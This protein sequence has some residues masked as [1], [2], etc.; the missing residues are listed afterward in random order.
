MHYTRT[1]LQIIL[2]VRCLPSPGPAVGPGASGAAPPAGLRY[3]AAAQLHV[4]MFFVNS[5]VFALN[6]FYIIEIVT[7]HFIACARLIYWIHFCFE[8]DYVR[9]E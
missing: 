6:G 8:I 7:R 2:T 4:D 1:L 5:H 3:D 9:V